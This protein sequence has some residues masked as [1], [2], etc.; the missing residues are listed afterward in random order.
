MKLTRFRNVFLI[1]GTM[2]VL[3]ALYLSDPDKGL[4]TG[5]LVLDLCVCVLAVAFA[6]VSRKA[7]MDYPEA[8]KQNLFARAG[9]SPTGAGLA[10]VAQAIIILGLLLLFGSRVHAATDVR[11]YVPTNAKTYA[12]MLVGEQVRFWADHPS[13]EKLAGLV[14]QES[15]ISLTHSRCWSPAS[16]L[17]TSREEGAGFGQITRAFRLNGA[18]RFDALADQ[19]NAHPELA[20]WTWGNV[21]QRPDLQLRAMVLMSRDNYKRIHQL[22]ANP[23][24]ALAFADAAYNGG[25]GGVQSDRRL[26]GMKA[27]CDP[28]KWFGN[29]EATCTKSKRAIYGSRNACDINREHVHMVM[30]VRSNKYKPFWGA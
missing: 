20:G 28:Q 4:S 14:E 12:P 24:D 27:G 30:L 11:T 21:Y 2:S 7:L 22:V 6:H 15:C 23:T 8:D 9:E 29:V 26:C 5:M 13:P 25:M 1:I 18:L 17:K 19:R 10:L 16:K 3:L